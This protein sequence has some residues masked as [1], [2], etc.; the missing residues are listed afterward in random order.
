MPLNPGTR[1]MKAC[2]EGVGGTV[3]GAGGRESSVRTREFAKSA[4]APPNLD[5]NLTDRH[6]QIDLRL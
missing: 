1:E 5:S 4:A 2:N 6:L 3:R